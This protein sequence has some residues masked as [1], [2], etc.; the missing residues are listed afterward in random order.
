MSLNQ[1]T[2][3]VVGPG[4]RMV[5]VSAIDLAGHPSDPYAYGCPERSGRAWCWGQLGHRGRSASDRTRTAGMPVH[6]CWISDR[7]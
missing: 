3:G 1:H 2:L 5:N 7:R 6:Q 4:E